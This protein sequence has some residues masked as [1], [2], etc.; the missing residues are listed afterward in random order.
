M[1]CPK[2]S[3]LVSTR[4]SEYQ[5][6]S[7]V[8]RALLRSAASFLSV[9]LC[10][11]ASPL[12]ASSSSPFL[13]RRVQETERKREGTKSSQ[14]LVLGLHSSHRRNDSDMQQTDKMRVESNFFVSV[15]TLSIFLRHLANRTKRSTAAVPS[16]VSQQGSHHTHGRKQPLA[17]KAWLLLRTVNNT[18]SS[19]YC[20]TQR[21][22]LTHGW[23]RRW[24]V[25]SA[26]WPRNL[27]TDLALKDRKVQQ[28]FW[29]LPCQTNYKQ[30]W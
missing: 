6:T 13:S 24:S 17:P 25:W 21:H 1:T 16:D 5:N 7:L 26:C 4:T 11:H 8:S 28:R 22:F 18:R 2:T 20:N 9:G 29:L 3:A 10:V 15:A 12:P 30:V 23:K 14:L 27:R 19:H